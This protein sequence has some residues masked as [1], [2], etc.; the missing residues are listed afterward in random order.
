MESPDPVMIR[1]RQLFAGSGPTRDELGP[2]AGYEGDVARKGA[3]RFLNKTDDPR[4][5]T[6]REVAQAIGV[7]VGV[8]EF[9]KEP[10]KDRIDPASQ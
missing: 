5:S 7:G 4:V 10:K 3:W 8:G 2:R 1:A 6:L 9:F